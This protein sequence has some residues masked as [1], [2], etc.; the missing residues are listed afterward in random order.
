[1][2]SL[3]GDD[4][5]QLVNQMNFN[6]PG[7]GTGWGWHQD[8]RFRKGG[9]Q[10]PLENYVQC[11]IALDVCNTETGGLR[12][13]PR[14]HELGSL[15]LDLDPDAS[16]QQFRGTESVTPLLNPGDG[17]IFN[18]FMVH[19][20]TPNRSAH[21]RRVFINGYAAKSHCDYGNAVL[22]DGAPCLDDADMEYEHD[23]QTVAKSSKY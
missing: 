17:V 8:Y 11:L 1:M 4:I 23:P 3:L 12:L 19:G 5:V 2:R 21:Q 15:K 10:N 7:I 18:P 6:P 20:S 13:I 16:E 14:S 9:L 22:R